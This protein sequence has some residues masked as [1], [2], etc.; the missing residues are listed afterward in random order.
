MS[1]LYYDHLLVLDEV[2]AE[3]KK[4][5]KSLEEKEELW[6]VVDEMVH[7]RVMGCVLDRLP[8]EHHQEFLEKFHKAPHDENILAYLKEKI[9]ENIEEI[10]RQEVGN[11]AY[12]L[13]NEIRGKQ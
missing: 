1:K 12:E 11:L 2:E 5:A 13:L 3:I 10:I 8:K 6:A 4:S 7:H 9:G